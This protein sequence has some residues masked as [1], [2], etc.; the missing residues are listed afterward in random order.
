MRWACAR[1]SL[2]SR[3]TATRAQSLRRRTHSSPHRA[4][5]SCSCSTA[6]RPPTP[7]GC[8]LV[9]IPARLATG[10]T[11]LT[12]LFRV[13]VLSKSTD[14]GLCAADVNCDYVG[15]LWTIVAMSQRGL[16]LGRTKGVVYYHSVTNS[17]IVPYLIRFRLSSDSYVANNTNAVP[18]RHVALR[19]VHEFTSISSKMPRSK[20]S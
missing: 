13:S 3:A 1:S 11:S 15:N 6:P 17:S 5:T 19:D 8:A 4:G 2:S 16:F 18:L 9:A 12:S 14:C 7:T 20:T 10:R